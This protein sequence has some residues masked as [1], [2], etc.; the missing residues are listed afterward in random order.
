MKLEVRHMLVETAAPMLFCQISAT[1]PFGVKGFDPHLEIK[2]HLKFYK[3]MLTMVPQH[4]EL[5]FD[6]QNYDHCIRYVAVRRSYYAAYKDTVH[7]TSSITHGMLLMILRM[8]DFLREIKA[9]PVRWMLGLERRRIARLRG[10]SYDG[11]DILHDP[12]HMPVLGEM[13]RDLWAHAPT[14]THDY[15]HLLA[16]IDDLDEC[17]RRSAE[18]EGIYLARIRIRHPKIRR[19]SPTVR[20]F[21]I[22]LVLAEGLTKRDVE[23]ISGGLELLKRSIS[24][25]KDSVTN[26]HTSFDSIPT[27]DTTHSFDLEFLQS[28]S[29]ICKKV[30]SRVVDRK[31]R[32]QAT[33]LISEAKECAEVIHKSTAHRIDSLKALSK[34]SSVVEKLL[35]SK[36]STSM[37]TSILEAIGRDRAQEYFTGLIA[38]RIET[39]NSLLKILVN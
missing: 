39:E 1:L 17:I 7:Q 6:H 14:M 9:S 34:E 29:R 11:D 10:L 15:I 23:L 27:H 16:C 30:P 35:H 25:L 8:H 31:V 37:E 19:S 18:D 24:D 2:R 33:A 4:Q 3:E 20:K 32:T 36:Q 28:C 21:D 22:L 38:S 12:A 26:P 13:T 5:A